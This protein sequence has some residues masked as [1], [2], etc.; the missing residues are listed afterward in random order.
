MGHNATA[1]PHQVLV[2][3][4]AVASAL[5]ANPSD[6][7]QAPIETV[8][9][10][11]TGQWGHAFVGNLSFTYSGT[12]PVEGWELT[13][14]SPF[15]ILNVWNSEIVSQHENVYTIRNVSWNRTLLPGDTITVGLKAAGTFVEPP[16]SYL[17]NGEI[18]ADTVSESV[19][20]ALPKDPAL[21][22]IPEVDDLQKE[23]TS[24]LPADKPL[25]DDPS[26]VEEPEAE[27][28]VTEQPFVE[29]PVTEQPPLEG[30]IG[31]ELI[32]EEAVVEEPV[33]DVPGSEQSAVED[34]IVELPVQPAADQSS[35]E[36]ELSS[37]VGDSIAS[38]TNSSLYGEALQKS[39]L[40]YEAQRSGALPDDNRIA[41]RGD[42]ALSDGA[43]VGVDLGGGYYDAG[44]HVKFGFPM[45]G[46]LTL[47]SWGSHRIS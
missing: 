14:E 10:A 20:I 29:Q 36:T 47:L 6:P 42:S 4:D 12:E 44:D 16:T 17:F 46:S 2:I 43:D 28:P 22:T 31:E 13:F 41:W 33:L 5:V 7:A 24:E 27:E 38:E 8:D 45:A 37:K 11:V 35:K 25:I 1:H 18:V 34:P 21:P 15:P 9:F 23:P 32:A 3:P 30:A 39:L 26:P 19:T 40:F